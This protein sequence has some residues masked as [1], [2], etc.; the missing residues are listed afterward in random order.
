MNAA[1]FV[2]IVWVLLLGKNFF[3]AKKKQ[4]TFV[5]L[6]WVFAGQAAV[7]APSTQILFDLHCSG[8][9]GLAGHGVPER[10]IPDLAEAG[11][12]ATTPAGRRYL[13]EVPGIA[14]SRLNNDD[15]A[16][17]LNWALTRFSRPALPANFVPFTAADVAA[18]RAN[19]ATDAPARRA[20]L[21]GGG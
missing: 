4:K 19:P 14:I 13:T 10:G 12:Y 11:R 9:H 15:A 18:G 8:C 16:K 7:A 20:T 3:F 6:I 21:L 1:R 5:C 17:I 2:Q